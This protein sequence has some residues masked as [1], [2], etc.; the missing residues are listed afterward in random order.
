MDGAFDLNIEHEAEAEHAGEDDAEHRIFLDA[1]VLLDEAGQK[2][3]DETG[4][5][6]PDGERDAGD[7]GDDDARQHGMGDGVT[8]Q[9]PA[10][11]NQQAGEEGHRDRD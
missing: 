2:R 11:Q 3:A 10:L 9:R 5:E 6:G 8:H 7:I 4:D 1:A